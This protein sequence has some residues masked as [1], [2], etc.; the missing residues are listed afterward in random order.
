MVGARISLESFK[1]RGLISWI[2]LHFT[3]VHFYSMWIACLCISQG[4]PGIPGNRGRIGVR[5]SKVRSYEEENFH[6][7]DEKTT[8]KNWCQLSFFVGPSW[9]DR[10]SWSDG[11]TWKR[12]KT[13][14]QLFAFLI[15]VTFTVSTGFPWNFPLVLLKFMLFLLH[16][17][18]LCQVI[19]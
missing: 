8:P 10:T 13:E 16:K 1:K 11:K 15:L 3:E 14:K 9:F 17:H 19:S 7:V 12:S 18:I 6:Q 5:G 2:F 4:P